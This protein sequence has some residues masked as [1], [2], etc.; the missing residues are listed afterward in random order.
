MSSHLLRSLAKGSLP[1]TVTSAP[2]VAAVKALHA[3][4]YVVVTFVK[5]LGKTDIAVVHRLTEAGLAASQKSHATMAS[6]MQG[7]LDSG[8]S[9]SV[10]IQA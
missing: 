8:D 1:I 10:K 9:S 7:S 3:A 6:G 2:E 4:E 5:E